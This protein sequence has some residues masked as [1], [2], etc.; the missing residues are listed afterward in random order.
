MGTT[1]TQGEKDG[2]L[3]TKKGQEEEGC[4]VVEGS[5]MLGPQ[6]KPTVRPGVRLAPSLS[7]RVP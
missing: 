5:W 3:E 7:P 2:T 1:D 4:L 6:G